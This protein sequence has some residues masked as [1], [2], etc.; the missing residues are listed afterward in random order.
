M[1]W[2]L[3]P[4]RLSYFD[5]EGRSSRKEF[6]FFM[7]WWWWLTIVLLIAAGMTVDS[8]GSFGDLGGVK[9]DRDVVTL[10]AFSILGLFSV[11]M[12]IPVI[13]IR[14]RRMHDIG[15]SGWWCWA[16]F[17]PYIGGIFMIATSVLPSQS[18]VNRWGK[19]PYNVGI[20]S[21]DRGV[22]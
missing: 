10:C 6:W 5:F 7:L 12:I 14:V 1:K 15:L 8:A 18:G 9:K 2:F 22:S 21:S 4:I 17:V 11:G 16:A 13:S 19:N 3:D 20:V